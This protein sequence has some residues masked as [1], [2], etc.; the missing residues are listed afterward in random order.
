MSEDRYSL[1][2]PCVRILRVYYPLERGRILLCADI[3]PDKDLFPTTINTAGNYSEFEIETNRP[4]FYVKPI[5]ETADA[6]IQAAGANSLVLTTADGTRDIYPFFHDPEQGTIL[7]VITFASSIL[8]REHNLRVYLPAG[9]EENP[10][11][12]YPVMYMQD[13][14]N[15]FFP[16]EA[17]LGREWGVGGTLTLLDQMNAVDRM[18]VVGIY[19]GDRGIEYVNPGYHDYGRSIVEEVKPLIDK[20]FRTERDAA[21]T[22]VMGSSLGGVVSFYMAWEWPHVFGTA[23]CLSSTFTLKD[24]LIDRV[25]TEPRRNVKFYI[26]SGWPG[27]NYEVSL[28]MA[29]ALVQRGYEYGRDVVHYAFPLATHAEPDW[30]ARLHLPLQFFASVPAIG[31]RRKHSTKPVKRRRA[32]ATPAPVAPV[33]SGPPA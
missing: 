28:A 30:A 31:S 29:I 5:L 10:L 19:A 15:L 27:D 3:F 11:R 1:E 25:L 24:N 32:R 6:R 9:Y 17:F 18:I 14:S 4:F 13:G 26:D 33:Q 8:K 7:D 22:G 23:A 21:S 20:R 12:S 2:V 16:E